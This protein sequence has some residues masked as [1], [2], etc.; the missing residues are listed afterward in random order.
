MFVGSRRPCFEVQMEMPFPGTT[1][2]QGRQFL[3]VEDQGAESFRKFFP[4]ITKFG[5]S[6]LPVG[7]GAINEEAMVR[8]PDGT[9]MYGVSFKGDLEGWRRKIIEA[10]EAN[11]LRWGEIK[12]GAIRLSNGDEYDLEVCH[13]ARLD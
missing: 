8:L 5:N 1:A 6:P 12:G 13:L 10:A 3:F 11:E 4:K 2:V 7:G 9:E